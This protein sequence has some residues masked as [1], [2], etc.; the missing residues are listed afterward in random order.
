[1]SERDITVALL[2]FERRVQSSTSAREVAFAAANDAFSVLKYDQA[3]VWMHDVFRRPIVTA[4]S[5]L[6]DPS[7]DSPYLQWLARAERAG[8]P[9]EGKLVRPVGLSELPEDVAADGHDW[10]H[11][12]LVFGRLQGPD[13]TSRGG[14]LFSRAEPFSEQ[15]LALAEWIVRSAGYGLWAWRKRRAAVSRLLARRSALFGSLVVLSVAVVLWAVQVPLTA[16]APAEITPEKPIPVT[17]PMDGIIRQ[18]MVQPNQVVKSGQVLAELDDTSLRNRQ[19]VAQK[20][21]EIAQADSRRAINKA[22]T[23]ESSR[24]ELQLLE[25]RVREKSAELAYLSDLLKRLTIT[26][27]QGGL[28]IF[29]STEEWIGR[30]VQPGERIMTLAD[31]SLI[32]VTIYVPPEDAVRLEPGAEVSVFLNV[33]PLESLPARIVGSSYE[34]LPQTDGSLAFV[35]QADLLPGHGFPRIGLRG[36]AKLHSEQV[37]LGYYLFRKPI[38]YLRRHLGV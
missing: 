38:A 9:T 2:E 13:G 12:H 1:M 31:P 15:E 10:C 37:S 20:A 7:G 8:G 24:T 17:S 34:A 21:L 28:A 33:N 19:L 29:S 18:I 30:P 25:A 36:T 23:D 3:V 16:L 14:M 35:V 5:G 32:R 27:P 22:F 26:A 6:A 4:A 11:E